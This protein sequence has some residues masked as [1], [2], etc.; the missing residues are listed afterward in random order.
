MI[1]FPRTQIP[2]GHSTAMERAPGT[3]GHL[4]VPPLW[5]L[6]LSSLATALEVR[7]H[8]TVL[9]NVAVLGYN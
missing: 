8:E 2:S 7:E 3:V 1:T 6:P 5:E 9:K 4:A